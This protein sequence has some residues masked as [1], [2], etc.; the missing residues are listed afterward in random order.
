VTKP[1]KPTRVTVQLRRAIKNSGA[2]LYRVSKES[3][4]PYAALHR[5]MAGKQDLKLATAEKLMGWLKMV[6]YTTELPR[7]HADRR[8]KG[9]SPRVKK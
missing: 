4:V 1:T 9:K 5:F 7:G 2:T 8:T 6:V 3:D